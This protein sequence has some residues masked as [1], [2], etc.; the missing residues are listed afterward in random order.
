MKDIN[1]NVTDEYEFIDLSN[2]PKDYDSLENDL[3]LKYYNDQR[4]N[5][6]QIANNLINSNI[7]LI[8]ASKNKD[9]NNQSVFYFEKQTQREIE[10]A[11]L[12]PSYEQI[13]NFYNHVNNSEGSSKVSL[14]EVIRRFAS[15]AKVEGLYFIQNYDDFCKVNCQSILKKYL[16]LTYFRYLT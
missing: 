6:Q 10:K 1:L 14:S 5:V 4:Y 12:F 8:E 9:K 11:G 7:D 13:S 16:S 15:M 2:S 3:I